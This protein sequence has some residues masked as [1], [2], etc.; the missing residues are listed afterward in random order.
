MN[1]RN[2]LTPALYIVPTPIGNL[3]DITL[4]ALKVLNEV[5]IIACEDTRNTGKLL[6]QLN[7]EKKKL[8]SYHNFNEKQKS[9]ELLAFIQNGKAV[10]LVSDAG[11]P[12]ISDPGYRIVNRAIELRVKII[13]LPGPSA[14]LTAL[15]VSGFDI[16]EFVFF[17]F[18][19]QK[20][21]RAKFIEK[22]ANYNNT[23]VLY[24]S[25]H[26]IIKLLDDL[27]N[28]IDNNRNICICRE[29]TKIHEEFIRGNIK[30]CKEYLLNK[31]SIKGE[32][33]I[34]IDKIK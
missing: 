34:I 28:F 24:E 13:P 29:L 33:V 21:G 5:D 17:G 6:K 18:P 14:F 1:N 10:A 11:T 30:E 22:I 8:I 12:L 19:P 9:D 3:E 31:T 15:T 27:S 16:N 26:K 25:P 2:E 4:R 32:F 7:I 23:I 20:K